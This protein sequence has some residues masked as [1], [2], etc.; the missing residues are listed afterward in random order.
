MDVT[1]EAARL[2]ALYEAKAVAELDEA[3][4]SPASSSVRW[5]GSPLART[6]FVKG[7]PSPDER[8][9]GTAFSGGDGRAAEKAAAALGLDGGLFFTCSRPDPAMDPRQR[10]ERLATQLEAVD[11]A[12]VIATDAE[13]AEDLAAAFGLADLPFG[14]PAR[15]LG[16]TLLAVDGLEASLGDEARKR[17]VW[18][19]MRTLSAGATA[20]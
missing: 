19:Q 17:R 5:S 6:A 7:S 16:R 8:A 18:A 9:G 1:A 4:P 20:P 2:R 14:Q 12:T 15:S 3:D 13:A 10:A 11:P